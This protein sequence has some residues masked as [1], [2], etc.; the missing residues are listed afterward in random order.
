MNCLNPKCREP[1]YAR[2]LCKPCYNVARDLIAADETSWVELEHR[3]K[4]LPKKNSRFSYR[5]EFFR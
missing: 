2:G 4:V 3:R 5:H 1:M